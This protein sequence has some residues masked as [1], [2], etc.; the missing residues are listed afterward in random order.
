MIKLIIEKELREIV[1]STKFALTFGVCAV[2]ILLAFYTGAKN[3]QVSMAQYGAAKTENV[4]QMEG[5]TDWVMVRNHRIFL[6]PEPLAALVTGISNDIG[7]SVT[8]Q[9]RGELTAQDSRFNDEPVFAVFR[10]LD[11]DFIFQIVLSLFAILFAYDAINGEK[12]R[13]TLRLAFANALPRAQYILGKI[14]GS[15]IALAVPLLIPILVGCLL[16]PI[17]GVNLTGDEWLRLSLIILSGL[18]YF[19]VFLMLSVFVSSLTYRTSSSFLLL[20]VIWIFSVLIIPRTSVLLAGRAVDVPSVDEIASQKNRLRTQLWAEDRKKMG[21]F[22]PTNTEDP[23]A[24]VSEF[25]KFMSDIAD[26]R[27]KKMN[28]LA[29]R[30]NEDRRN[31][32]VVQERLAFSFARL[33]PTATFSLISTNLASTSMALKTHYLSEATAYQKTYAEFMQEKTGMNIGG[34]AM[35]FRMKR[36]D[37][38]EEV[39]KPIDPHELPEFQYAGAPFDFAVNAALPDIGLLALFNLLFFAGAFVAFLRYD[40]R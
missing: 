19:G 21:Q 27:E 29:S 39:E 30:L 8:V 23:Q 14:I 6:P 26:E 16:L 20:L 36:G 7:R 17:M 40:L 4:R 18:M 1:G 22:K 25:N 37:G 33:S 34:G 38:E 2:L 3:Y 9:G 24:M 12:E 15:F 31:K 32:Q 11:L 28:E 13:G 10:F 35:I 5:L